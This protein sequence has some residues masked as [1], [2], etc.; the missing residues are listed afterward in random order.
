MDLR[1]RRAEIPTG[2]PLA[3]DY[4]VTSG[5]RP[6]GRIVR[7][8]RAGGAVAWFWS[9]TIFPSSAADRAEIEP[10]CGEGRIPGSYRSGRPFDSVTMWR[11]S[12]PR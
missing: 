3:D 5:G 2:N 12:R 9:F 8:R 6:V 10:G 11:I 7:V 4:I 1:L